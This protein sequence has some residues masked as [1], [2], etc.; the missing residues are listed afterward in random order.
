MVEVYFAILDIMIT[1]IEKRFD[2]S[3]LHILSAIEAAV[4]KHDSY[5]I[6]KVCNTYSLDSK[7]FEA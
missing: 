3:D 6:T 7:N 1:Q 2:E 5:S 4:L